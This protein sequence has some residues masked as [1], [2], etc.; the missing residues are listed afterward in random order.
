MRIIE[1][2][3][4]KSAFE[5]WL[6]GNLIALSDSLYLQR[7]LGLH[8]SMGQYKKLYRAGEYER[9]EESVLSDPFEEH[10]CRY[11]TRSLHSLT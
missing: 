8:A 5:N 4:G 9:V 3:M 6:K 1:I 2:W 11:S 7:Q 10:F